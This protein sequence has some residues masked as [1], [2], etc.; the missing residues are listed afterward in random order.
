MTNISAHTYI[1]GKVSQQKLTPEQITVVKRSS[2]RLFSR[3]YKNGVLYYGTEYSKAC[4][5]RKN[6]SI[7]AY[8][9][10]IGEVS[11]G[12][13]NVFVLDP[14]PMAL[15][16]HYEISS[17]SLMQMEVCRTVLEPHKEVDL[18]SS[19]I[20]VSGGIGVDLIGVNIN[21]ILSKGV[22]VHANSKD[23]L[24]IRPNDFEFH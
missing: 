21:S 22:Q 24:T 20:I 15:L 5:G 11:F 2:A 17:K 1:V 16:H 4:T 19:Y 9:N 12:Q 14:Y 3:L 10:S 6:N 7:C 23:L 18:L 13:I 8:T